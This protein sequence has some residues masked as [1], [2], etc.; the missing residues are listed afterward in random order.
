ML[1]APALGMYKVMV[2]HVPF[3]TRVLA[4]RCISGQV[5]TYSQLVGQLLMLS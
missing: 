5:K 4:M 2:D 1:G 3:A